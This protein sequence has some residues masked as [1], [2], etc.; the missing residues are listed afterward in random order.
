MGLQLSGLASGFDW[1]SVVDQLIE[2]ERVPQ[3]KLKTEKTTNTSKL[4]AFSTVR[5]KLT[6][7]QDAVKQ[8]SSDSLFSQRSVSIA[9]SDS[10]W[11]ASASNGATNGSYTLNVS[12]VATRSSRSGANDISAPL[13]DSADVSELLVSDLRL[14]VSIKAGAFTVNGARVEVE[15]TDTLG[16]VFQKISDA[17]GGDVAATYDEASDKVTLASTEDPA[18]AISLGGG[19]DTSNFLYA[20]KLYNTGGTSIS[21][22]TK[23]GTVALRESL[24]DAG[25]GAGVSAVDGE[26]D[27]FF[28]INGVQIDFNVNTDTMQSVMARVNESTA[29]VAMSYDAVNDRFALANSS[30]GNLDLTV[31]ESAGGLLAALG[32][33][34]GATVDLGDNAEFTVNGGGLI[35]SA[36]N[37]LDASVHGITG[38]TVNVTGTGEE[39]ISVASD[40]GS[41]ET[42]IR[43]F[44]TKYND[45]QSYVD[46]QTKVTV[47]SDGKVS[48]GL[49]ADNREITDMARQLRNRVF[50]EVPGLTG[51]VRRLEAVGIDFEGSSSQLSVR[52]ASKLT[53]ALATNLEEVKSLF[54]TA[55]TG[56]TGR[57]D[58]Y[59]TSLTINGGLVDTQETTIQR[60]NS[61]LDTQI[62][63]IERRLE[64]ERSRLEES[65][66]RME[67]AQSQMSSQLASL[68]SI[69]GTS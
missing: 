36:S 49:F 63:D 45:F 18:A 50:A 57:I 58:S 32:L 10:T 62:A 67:E 40:T 7:L 30:T 68:Q 20:L 1:K 46:T 34:S 16:D 8:L 5:S 64:A 48:S 21:S 56:I 27:G 19:G 60:Q 44:V 15:E 41:I 54:T 29:G 28:V 38:V 51:T 12:K 26:G 53:E 43:N 24:A 33:T 47:G 37:A 55:S 25:L 52:D 61:N 65:F 39:T 22:A 11:S 17:T 59:V 9:N 13:H 14:A 35:V 3:D 69:L 42:G 6:A 31:S 4:S 2:L 23:L 66:I